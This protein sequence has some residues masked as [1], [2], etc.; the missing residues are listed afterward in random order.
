MLNM[1]VPKVAKMITTKKD[2]LEYLEADRIA[3]QKSRKNL[4]YSEMKFGN[5]R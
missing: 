5:L 1:I 3:L 4:L 2:L